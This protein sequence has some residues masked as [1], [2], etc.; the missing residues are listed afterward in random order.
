MVSKSSCSS[1]NSSKQWADFEKTMILKEKQAKALKRR[2]TLKPGIMKK[3][4]TT[5]G[6]TTMLGAKPDLRTLTGP[7]TLS[8]PDDNFSKPRLSRS[9]D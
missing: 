7:S 4:K 2:Y 1:Y 3:S 6:E 9:A 8:K 5:R